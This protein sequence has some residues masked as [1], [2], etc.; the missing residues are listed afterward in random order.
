MNV[1]DKIPRSISEIY[2]R[3]ELKCEQL[4]TEKLD[5]ETM[6][7]T[8]KFLSLPVLSILETDGKNN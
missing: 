3:Y 2:G 7:Q 6:E 4:L 8:I 5:K 1:I